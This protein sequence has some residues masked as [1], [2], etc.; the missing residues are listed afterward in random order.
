[1]PPGLQVPVMLV[2]RLVADWDCKPYSAAAAAAWADVAQTFA[3]ARS[4]PFTLQQ[5]GVSTQVQEQSGLYSVLVTCTA[6]NRRR[7]N[8]LRLVGSPGTAWIV[9]VH[10][11]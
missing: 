3:A 9:C 7:E 8:Q 10:V 11:H 1:M 4:I 5:V 6:S 2:D